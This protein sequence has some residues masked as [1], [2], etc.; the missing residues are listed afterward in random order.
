LSGKCHACAGQWPLYISGARTRV[1]KV[2]PRCRE[3]TFPLITKI[4]I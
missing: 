3:W 1:E 2:K 4:L